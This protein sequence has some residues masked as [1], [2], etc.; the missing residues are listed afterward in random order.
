MYY[1]WSVFYLFV[2]NMLWILIQNMLWVVTR[3]F[4][5]NILYIVCCLFAFVIKEA[6]DLSL[7]SEIFLFTST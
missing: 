3:L 6:Y 1:S 4:I 7:N 2:A 5:Q